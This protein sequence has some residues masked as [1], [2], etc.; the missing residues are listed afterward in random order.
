M[1]GKV[2][3]YLQT[4]RFRASTLIPCSVL[5]LSSHFKKRFCDILSVSVDWPVLGI[6]D[7]WNRIP[8]GLLRLFS[9]NEHHVFKVH[10]FRSVKR[11]TTFVVE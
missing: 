7:K 6:S 5:S 9:F 4:V 2:R 8:R 1:N 11:F 10:P 3:I